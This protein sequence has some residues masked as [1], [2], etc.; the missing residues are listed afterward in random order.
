MASVRKSPVEAPFPLMPFLN[1]DSE[2]DVE[3][4]GPSLKMAHN[5]K[6]RKKKKMVINNQ[7]G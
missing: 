5:E 3:H 6:L 7:K 1:W 4:E 2:M